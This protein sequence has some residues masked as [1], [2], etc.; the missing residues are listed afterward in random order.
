MA[1]L[2]FLHDKGNNVMRGVHTHRRHELYYLVKGKTKYIN[3]NEIYT[4]E[5]GNLVFTPKGF[6]HMTESGTHLNTERYL[7]AFDESTFDDDTR[8]ILDGLSTAVLSSIPVNK[9]EALEGLFASLERAM[10]G[11]D[12]LAEAERKILVLSILHFVCKYRRKYEPRVS[13]SDKIVH[14]AS[15]YVNAHYSEDITLQTLSRTLSVSESYLSRRFKEV[16]GV[17]I[18]E[19]ITFVRIMNAERLLKE[20]GRSIT[21]ISALCGFNDPNYFSTVFKRIKGV[22]PLKFSKSSSV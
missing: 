22:T 3:G 9:R 19:Y 11:T 12:E 5:E 7:I 6:Y 10:S 2:Y 1:Y 4:V 18:N 20:G 8:V 15:D 14:D 13:E 16:S 17:G 21:E